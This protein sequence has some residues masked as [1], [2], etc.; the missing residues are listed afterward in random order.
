MYRSEVE[1]AWLKEKRPTSNVPQLRDL[2]LGVR[3]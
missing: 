1:E 2:A 3:C